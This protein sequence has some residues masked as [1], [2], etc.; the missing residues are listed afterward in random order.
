MSNFN[1]DLLD[2]GLQGVMGKDRCQNV[3]DEKGATVAKKETVAKVGASKKEKA[4]D[5]RWEPVKEE[6][7]QDKLKG[8]AKWAIGFGGLSLLLFYWNLEGLM[9]SSVAVPSMCV[10]TMMAGFGIGK[11]AGGK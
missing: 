9:A 1:G 7:W 6:T 8:C 11:T 4:M 3:W 5:A 2:E 10:C